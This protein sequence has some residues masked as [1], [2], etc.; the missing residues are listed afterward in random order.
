LKKIIQKQNQMENIIQN[1]Y[2]NTP[3]N[4]KVLMGGRYSVAEKYFY[5]VLCY[6]HKRY[7]DD[8]GNFIGHDISV[9][10][11][12]PSFK[13]FGLSQRIWKQARKRLKDDGLIE[14]EHVYGKKG[15]RVGTQY[16]LC[17]MEFKEYSK[18]VHNRILNRKT[19]E[20]STSDVFS[21]KITLISP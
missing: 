9:Q 2:F 14:F 6:L 16:R 3:N 5:I 1:K 13:I 7:K 11:G 10:K 19:I 20:L 15:Y 21:H 17:D 8:S 4:P 12:V 18:E